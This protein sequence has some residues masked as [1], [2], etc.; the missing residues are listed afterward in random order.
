MP[1]LAYDSKARW[2]LAKVAVVVG[3]NFYKR[4]LR[5]DKMG[6]QFY[7]ARD[8]AEIMGICYAK[9]LAFIKYSGIT[10]VRINRTYLVEKAVFERFVSET[11]T[12]EVEL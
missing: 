6:K 4:S 5:E 2:I 12:I 1:P 10:Y 3:G 9:A 8:I 7:N 11:K